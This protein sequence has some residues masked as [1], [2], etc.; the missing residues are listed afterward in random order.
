[1]CKQ[2]L[3]AH[4]QTVC[5]WMPTGLGWEQLSHSCNR[6]RPPG[7]PHWPNAQHLR[8]FLSN[9]T[10]L[11]CVGCQRCWQHAGLCSSRSPEPQFP[12]PCLQAGLCLMLLF[13]S[14]Y[15]FLLW[16]QGPN[17]S[18]PCLRVAEPSTPSQCTACSDGPQREQETFHSSLKKPLGMLHGDGEKRTEGRKEKKEHHPVP[19]PT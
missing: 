1:M 11:H 12:L 7:H 16:G 6:Q 3:Q 4:S 17:Q 14:S 15:F 10:S 18:L 2:A 19:E 8:A 13:I 5:S 9:T